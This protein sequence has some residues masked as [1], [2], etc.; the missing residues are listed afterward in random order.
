[1]EKRRGGGVAGD[2]GARFCVCK[3]MMEDV[4]FLFEAWIWVWR[5]RSSIFCYDERMRGVVCQLSEY[6]YR[7]RHLPTQP[8]HSIIVGLGFH[9]AWR[10][11]RCV[12]TR[13]IMHRSNHNAV[14]S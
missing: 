4:G 3:V 14:Y 2:R 10:H 13:G 8:S 6:R 1:M 5:G 11:T 12:L 9:D 7:R